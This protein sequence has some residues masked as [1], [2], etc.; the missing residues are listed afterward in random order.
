MPFAGKTTFIE[1]EFAG[2]HYQHLPEHMLMA[3]DFTVS[4]WSE[5]PDEIIA[6][7]R[8]FLDLESARWALV[9]AS[10][11]PVFDR[12][13]LSIMAYLAARVNQHEKSEN[14]LQNYHK[15]LESY[16]FSGKVKLARRF[17]FLDTPFAEI[18][19]R[20]KSNDRKCEAFL[21]ESDTY[22]LMT[23]YYKDMLDNLHKEGLVDVVYV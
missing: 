1:K 19:Q 3:K 4:A 16:F 12:S 6:R 10:K 7:Q 14:I 2:T 17:F 18:K 15:L 23:A 13:V 20:V 8:Y 11:T 9:D 5:Q 22:E 21:L